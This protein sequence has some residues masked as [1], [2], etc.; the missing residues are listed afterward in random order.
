MLLLKQEE[1]SSNLYLN[2]GDCLQSGEFFL[3]FFRL[4]NHITR[5]GAN[6][7][8]IRLSV[9]SSI[10]KAAT[11][12]IIRP[13]FTLGCQIDEYTRLFGTKERDHP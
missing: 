6:L 12:P 13:F 1:R 11:E 10:L 8:M 3:G 9:N 2:A 5:A 7:A 4:M